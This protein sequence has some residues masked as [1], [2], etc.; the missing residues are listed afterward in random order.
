MSLNP[1]TTRYLA[2]QRGAVATRLVT[3]VENG[4]LRIFVV[5]GSI[6]ALFYHLSRR[7]V[8]I[9]EDAGAE[10]KDRRGAQVSGGRLSG[11]GDLSAPTRNYG[12]AFD[13]N[14]HLGLPI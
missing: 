9:L 10:S 13:L 3:T 2:K 8:G 5:S 14:E 12:L 7:A 1:N 11:I 6:D 4:H